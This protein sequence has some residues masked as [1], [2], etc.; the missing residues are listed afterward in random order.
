VLGYQTLGRFA[1]MGKRCA[2]VGAETEEVH[3]RRG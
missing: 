3:P 2:A 1:G